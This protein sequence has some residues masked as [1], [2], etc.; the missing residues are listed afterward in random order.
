MAFVPTAIPIRHTG[1]RQS[2]AA[3]QHNVRRRRLHLVTR[4]ELTTDDGVEAASTPTKEEAIKVD[5]AV[6]EVSMP[7]LYDGWFAPK[8]ELATQMRAAVERAYTDGIR[9]MELQW[10]CVPNLE[11][12]AA[13]TKLNQLF[14]IQ[15]AAE[16]GMSAAA[17]YQLVKRYLA[18]FSNIYWAREVASAS[19]FR[20]S[21]AFAICGDSISMQRAEC[22][23]RNVTVLRK[24]KKLEGRDVGLMIDPRY[25]DAWFNGARMRSDNKDGCVVFLNSQFS[26]TYGLTGPRRGVMKETAVVYYLKRVTRGYIF[27]SYPGPWLACLENPDMSIEVVRQF[28]VEPKLATVAKLV[29]EESNRRYGGFNNDRY[30]KGFGGRL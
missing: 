23:L 6:N 21:N 11:E 14:G 10:P 17:D 25:D 26:E 28:E 18:S 16:L 7:K 4:A 2:C 9:Q 3:G 15:V 8:H 27:F 30:V 19:P 29:R 1:W 20:D 24:A 12:I 13:G 5:D 22:S